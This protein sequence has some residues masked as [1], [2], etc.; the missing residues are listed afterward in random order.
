MKIYIDFETRSEVD[1]KKVGAW[2]YSRHPS[3]EIL[4][5]GWAIDDG[6]LIQQTPKEIEADGSTTLQLYDYVHDSRVIWVAHNAFFEQCIWQNILEPLFGYSSLPIER[7][8]CTMA[9]AA[10][11]N[12]PTSLTA[13]GAA[14]KLPIQKDDAGHRLMLKMSK[15]RRAKTGPKWHETPEDLE[16]LYQYCKTDVETTRLLDLALPDL[17]HKEQKI[18][19]LDQKINFRGIQ[20]DAESVQNVLG[21][22]QV[23]TQK[24]LALFKQA[25][26]GYVEKPTQRAK[27]LLWLQTNGLRVYDTQARTL[28]PYL[29]DLYLKP[30]VRTALAVL[31]QLG[32]S[33]TAKY[34]KI[35]EGIDEHGRLREL[36]AYHVAGTGRWGGRGFQPHNLPLPAKV[37]G[38]Y[39]DSNIVVG[40]IAQND[41]ALLHDSFPDFMGAL[42]SAI[43]GMVIAKEG[44]VLVGGDYSQIEARVLAWLADEEL[45]LGFFRR[46]EDPY[47]WM[48]AKIFGISV[49]SVTKEQRQS[50]GKP[51]VL[52][53]GFQCGANRFSE[54]FGIELELSKKCVTT[55]R[56]SFPNIPKFWYALERA[57]IQAVETGLKIECGKVTFALHKD[58]LY[59]KLPSGRCLA[60]YKPFLRAKEVPWST[61]E[62]PQYKKTLFYWGEDATNHQFGEIHMYGGKWA[63]NITQAVARD[64]MAEAMLRVE[65]AGYPVV[66][67]IHDEIFSEIPRNPEHQYHMITKFRELMEILPEWASDLPIKVEG[68]CRERY[69][70]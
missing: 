21:M 45:L 24:Q 53:C 12:L 48:A 56:E 55:Y 66:M 39:L 20:V 6:E 32:R 41:Y 58:F 67:T 68:W 38:T 51:S 46:N 17:T 62:E 9:K 35:L 52:G 7:W 3:T 59:C 31:K 43:R 57:A 15:P 69:K 26:G 13:A 64:I 14:L 30:N 70:K 60:Y 2:N 16:Q 18:W 11:A 65:E 23:H 36:L 44:H 42:S 25:T 54:Q 49:A 40:Y 61:A 37:E 29:D 33:S 19:C 63:E 28:E 50:P 10:A 22:I 4:C 1:L 27:F 5:I 47:I 34:E 8:R